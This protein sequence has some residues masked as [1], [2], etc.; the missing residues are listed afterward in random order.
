MRQLKVLAVLFCIISTAM[1]QKPET[2]LEK[3]KADYTIEKVFIHFDKATYTAGETV[4]FK[5]YIA[6][7]FLPA[8]NSTSFKVELVN[9]SGNIVVEKILPVMAGTATG[10]IDLL[11]NLPQGVYLI[12]AYTKWMMNFGED[13][14]YHKQISIFNPTNTKPEFEKK[15]NVV[16]NFFPEGGYIIANLSNTIACKANDSYGFPVDADGI[17]KNSK[18]DTVTSFST[19]HN[20]M[21]VFELLAKPDEM[22]T[23]IC[24]FENGSTYE[25]KLPAVK[26]YGVNLQVKNDAKG[27]TFIIQSESKYSNDNKPAYLLGQMENTLLFKAPLTGDKTIIAGVIPTKDLPTGILQLTV[28]DAEDKP[29]TERLT[30]VNN[31]DFLIEPQ[32]VIDTL[33]LKY[34]AKNSFHF[35]VPDSIEGNFS[36]AITD[37][38]KTIHSD[39]KENIIST[40]L[41]SADLKGYIHNPAYYFESNDDTHK[42]NLELVLLTH[43]WRRLNWQ[44]VLSNKLPPINHKDNNYISVAGKAYTANKKKLITDG[45]VSLIIAT[46]DSARN[47]FNMPVDSDGNFSMQGIIFED[48]AKLFFRYEK[49]NG[50]YQQMLL[51]IKTPAIL[52]S[53]NQPINMLWAKYARPFQPYNQALINNL[54]QNANNRLGKDVVDLGNINVSSRRNRSLA[55]QEVESRYTTGA[56]KSNANKILDFVNDPPVSGVNNI[57]DYIKS[58]IAGVTVSGTPPNY[59]LN[60]RATRSLSG[61]M[62]PMTLFLDEIQ[63]S[64]YML[65]MIRLEQVAMIKVF[66]AGFVGA[67]GNGPGGTLAVYTKKGNDYNN[68]DLNSNYNNISVAGYSVTREFYHPNYGSKETFKAIDERTTLYWNPYIVTDEVNRMVK[69]SFYNSDTAK[70]LKLVFT[71]MTTKGKLIAVEKILE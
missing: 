37:E 15:N 45:N 69:I 9:D 3:I 42:D 31:N 14:F 68:Y 70:K 43:G 18:G 19:L 71:G 6:A 59:T 67:E 22:Y 13:N 66:G 62:T 25:V 23:A 5:A 29:L 52:Q 54:Y 63:T 30:F 40:L 44:Q 10:Q 39:S 12:R 51:D 50:N 17:I 60:Y 11:P 57:F 41:L 35:T 2:A 32:F 27:K 34:R 48:T 36:I 24:H 47:F 38:A 61:G 58:R 20:G 56:F 16:I 21:G 64:A 8:S 1:A 28:F 49:K 55:T 26:R 33:Q 65:S 7:G 46:K 53:F 4:W